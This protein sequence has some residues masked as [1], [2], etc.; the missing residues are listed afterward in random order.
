MQKLVANR[1]GAASARAAPPANDA[2][3][4]RFDRSSLLVVGL[5]LLLLLTGIA[6]KAYRLSLPTTGWST[7]TA[8]DST[9]PVFEHNLLGAPLS[10]QPGDV[11]VGLDGHSLSEIHARAAR[12]QPTLPENY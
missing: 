4:R 3:E 9:V 5:A 6:Q 1:S 11:F 8:I 12:F 2:N 10:L 7:M